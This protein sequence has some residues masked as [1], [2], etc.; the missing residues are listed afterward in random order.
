MTPNFLQQIIAIA[1]GHEGNLKELLNLSITMQMQIRKN[2][3]VRKRKIPK[4]YLFLNKNLK[5]MDPILDASVAGPLTIFQEI[6]T[7]FYTNV[8]NEISER[9]VMQLGMPFFSQNLMLSI[10]SRRS[11]LNLLPSYYQK[12]VSNIYEL[13]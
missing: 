13:L 10:S 2:L 5:Q 1:K 3:K 6:V 9:K 11:L 7:L 12:G 8:R 4:K